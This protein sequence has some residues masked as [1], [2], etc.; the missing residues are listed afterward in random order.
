MVPQARSS[1]W[2]VR[3]PLC[4]VRKK[5]AVKACLAEGGVLLRRSGC[6]ALPH[7]DVLNG[8]FRIIGREAVSNQSVEEMARHADE[9]FAGKIH[10]L[11]CQGLGKLVPWCGATGCHCKEFKLDGMEPVDSDMLKLRCQFRITKHACVKRS[12]QKI[13]GLSTTK[14]VIKG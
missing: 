13:H 10:L 5:G 11:P 3:K 1:L 8:I 9:L 6:F 2:A 7:M 14:A 4:K 12:N